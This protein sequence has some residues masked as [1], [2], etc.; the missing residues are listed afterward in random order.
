MKALTICLSHSISFNAVGLWSTHSARARPG[1]ALEG[2]RPSKG[3]RN[4]Q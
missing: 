2:A 3:L 4:K 1:P